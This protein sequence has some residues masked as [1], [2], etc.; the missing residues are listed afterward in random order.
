MAICN[1]CKKE[2]ETN[3]QLSRSQLIFGSFPGMHVTFENRCQ[4][5]EKKLSKSLL[6]TIK[7]II[8][9]RKNYE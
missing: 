9:K 4:K 2:K 8:S 7:E 3:F 6:K 1:M 5:C